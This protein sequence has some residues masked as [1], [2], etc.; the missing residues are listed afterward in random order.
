MK[1]GFRGRLFLGSLLVLVLAI[2][3]A[4]TYLERQLRWL[5]ENRTESHLV[6][7][8]ET[9]R[10]ALELQSSDT[11]DYSTTAGK[12]ASAS[13]A[14]V[15][16]IASDGRV[17][18][19]SQVTPQV[20]S[21]MGNHGDRSEVREALQD[22]RGMARRTSATVRQPLLY[23]AT[24]VSGCEP[25]AV[26]RV[27]MPA[28]RS[29]EAIATLRAVLAIGGLLALA[30]S[31]SV[32]WLSAH[33]ASRTVRGLYLA[34][35]ALSSGRQTVRVSSRASDEVEAVAGS[36]NEMAAAL[37][38]AV[39]EL[40]NERDRFGAVL[41]SMGEAVVVVDL[42]ERITLCNRS[43]L[44]MMNWAE[45][46]VGQKLMEA[47]RQPALHD[48]V[49]R[50]GVEGARPE[51]V[52]IDVQG[53]RRLLVRAAAMRGAERGVALVMR[54]ITELR[55]LENIRRDFVAN[56]SHEL[57]TPVST[58]RATAETL[59]GGALDDR[60]HAERF[61]RALLRHA[62][63]LSRTISDLLDLSRLEAGESRLDCQRA[64]VRAAVQ[65]A[66]EVVESEARRKDISLSIE[67][68]DGAAVQAD[69][70]ALEQILVNLLENAVKYTPSGG[71]VR[72]R[73]L[74]GQV[75]GEQR[76][77]VEDDGP[78]IDALHRT[79]IFERFYRLDPG[80]SRDLGGTGLGLSIVKHL[81]EAMGGQVGVRPAVPHGSVF[82]VRLAD[83]GTPPVSSSG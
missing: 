70:K 75:P 24:R 82:W 80:R 1:V 16:L 22:G 81:A 77:E 2:A 36:I 73:L 44:A 64:A 48:L 12:L 4:S 79:R 43:A 69:E 13:G 8:A 71:H 15:T 41:E 57:R 67:V 55:R 49:G 42:R 52:E 56:V 5:I 61:L 47:V 38:R 39:S 20:Q 25:I 50:V 19:D 59:L 3:A 11:Q 18:A 51:E 63:R 78:G 29:Q 17:L 26:V 45:P 65:R 76:I 40:A 53:T 66:W 33:Y 32:S 14:R 34:T 30:F 31:A 27:A 6:Q 28:A 62:E 23:A 68:P 72:V 21:A 37:E 10:A 83:P 7:L 58:I 35:R 9:A 46:P 74:P 60:E 54:D